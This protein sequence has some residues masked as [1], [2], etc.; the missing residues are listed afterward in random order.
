MEYGTLGVISS[1]WDW[2]RGYKLKFLVTLR[3]MSEWFLLNAL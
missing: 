2:D 1:G 3:Y